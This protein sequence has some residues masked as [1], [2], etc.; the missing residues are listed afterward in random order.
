[1]HPHRRQFLASTGSLLAF[2][3]LGRPAD[4]A[5]GVVIGHPEA[6]EAGNAA[7][8][9]GGNAVDAVV[10][11]ALVAGVV[12]LPST[13][14]GGY[15][16]HLV[17]ARPNGTAAAI[18]FNTTAPA[19]ATPEMVKADDRGRAGGNAHLHGPLPAAPP[20]LLAR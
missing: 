3:A 17:L 14:I 18:D 7:L 10:T 15:G 2:P 4:E 5:K 9:A 12:A 13:G 16:G 11:A 20:G 1:M 8:A 6:A 19:A